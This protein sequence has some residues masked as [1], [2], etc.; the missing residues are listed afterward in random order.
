[1]FGCPLESFHTIKFYLHLFF[2]NDPEESLHLLVYP[3]I[4]VMLWY[5]CI[6]QPN[7]VESSRINTVFHFCCIS[8]LPS[9]SWCFID[10]SS[11]VRESYQLFWYP[12]LLLTGNKYAPYQPKPL[13]GNLINLTQN[14]VR[15]L[16]YEMKFTLK[17]EQASLPRQPPQHFSLINFKELVLLL[18]IWFSFSRV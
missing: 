5:Y 6:K 10:Q 1:M 18:W 9:C 15:E 3:V 13:S 2:T 16:M 17:W 4:T 12:F 11:N 8:C 7:Y 14:H